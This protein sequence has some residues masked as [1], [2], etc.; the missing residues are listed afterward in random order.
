MQACP[1]A[2]VK[3]NINCALD[4]ILVRNATGEEVPHVC[5]ICDKLLKPDQ[6]ALLSVSVLQ[7]NQ[8]WLKAA[9][10]A[11]PISEALAACYRYTAYAGELENDKQ[12]IHDLQL[13]PR[14]SYIYSPTLKPQEGFTVCKRL[15][16]LPPFSR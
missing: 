1:S 2:S 7:K 5:L 12:W 4:D 13:S 6:V 3:H 11:G 15:L 9:S 8:K 14:A 10:V 16:P